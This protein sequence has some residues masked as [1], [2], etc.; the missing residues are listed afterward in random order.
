MF[1]DGFT[2][3]TLGVILCGV[4]PGPSSSLRAEPPEKQASAVGNNPTVKAQDLDPFNRVAYIP[5]SSDP[6]TIR[7]EKAKSV[8]VPTKI[9]YTADAHYC[10]ELAMFREPGGSRHCPKGR[11]GS[12]TPAFEVTYSFHGPA[13]ASD[14]F[15]H[16][17]SQFHILFRP[18]ELS[19]QV[20]SALLDKKVS[21]EQKAS[22]FT[23][24]TSRDYVPRVVIDEGQSRLCETTHMIG[25]H[26]HPIDPTCKDEIVYKTVTKPSGY[27][28]VK[29]DPSAAQ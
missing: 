27:L 15:G 24:K 7:F 12:P 1:R 9:I 6:S 20:Q 26:W 3:V 16:T 17:H 10:A 25:G 13:L 18:D 14:E 28:K 11:K 21:R 5:A 2:V 22:Y 8:E 4:P 19:P 29:V 23:V